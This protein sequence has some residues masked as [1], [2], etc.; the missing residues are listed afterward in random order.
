LEKNIIEEEGKQ[1]VEFIPPNYTPIVRPL[2]I[3]FNNSFKDN[4]KKIWVRD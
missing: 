4:L 3:T 1:F 2:D